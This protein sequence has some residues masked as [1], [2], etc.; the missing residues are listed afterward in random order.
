MWWTVRPGRRHFKNRLGDDAFSARGNG[1]QYI[2][3]APSLKIVAVHTADWRW[4]RKKVRRS[5]VGKLLTAVLA[6]KMYE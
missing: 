6:A 5:E 1:G 2:I 4:T 3:V